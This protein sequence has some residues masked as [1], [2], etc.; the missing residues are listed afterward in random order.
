MLFIGPIDTSAVSGAA[1][2]AVMKSALAPTAREIERLFTAF[3]QKWLCQEDNRLAHHW[4][5]ERT[6][7]F[8]WGAAATLDKLVKPGDKVEREYRKRAVA[9]SVHNY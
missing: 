8:G 5:Q 6:A 3:L 9:F 1:E 2:A 7:I 4:F